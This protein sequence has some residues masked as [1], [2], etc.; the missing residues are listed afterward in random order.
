[1]LPEHDGGDGLEWWGSPK[2]GSGSCP[3]THWGEGG[4]AGYWA[5][6]G[7]QA[8][9]THLER[10]ER[11]YIVDMYNYLID[12]FVSNKAE[13]MICSACGPH[14][15]G[16]A[17]AG[18]LAKFGPTVITLPGSAINGTLIKCN[19]KLGGPGTAPLLLPKLLSPPGPSQQLPWLFF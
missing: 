3:R 11:K 6:P 16:G 15:V 12:L 2:D 18:V 17:T 4:W 5:A 7:A 9:S 19:E 13:H 14:F 10:L 1:M 8:Q